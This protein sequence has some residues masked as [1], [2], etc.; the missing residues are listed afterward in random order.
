MFLL[1]AR[2]IALQKSSHQDIIEQ[3]QTYERARFDVAV[4]E[5]ALGKSVDAYGKAYRNDA[6]AWIDSDPAA[7]PR[8]R[9]IAAAFALEV[10]KIRFDADAKSWETLR[11]TIEW[12]CEQLRLNSMPLRGEHEWYLASVALAQRTLSRRWL[13]GLPD[14]NG[15]VWHLDHAQ[16]RFPDEARF[17]LVRAESQ[18]FD[19][20]RNLS[21]RARIAAITSPTGRGGPIAQA[22]SDNAISSFRELVNDLRV[23]PDA[24]IRVAHLLLS[25]DRYTSALEH[26]QRAATITDDA[27]TRYVAFVLEG[28][29]YEMLDRPADAG[30]AYA[31]ALAVMPR[32]QSA[33]LALSS[34]LLLSNQAQQAYDLAER[35][36]A[37]S[38][39]DD[40]WRLY[41]YGEFVRWPAYIAQLREAIK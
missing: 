40:P 9:L 38:V 12:S 13:T 39:S 3:L 23:A 15:A 14:S 28:K 2:V 7:R 36:L 16:A 37:A 6:R 22:Q 10:A 25:A 4:H 19:A 34:L 11:D 30:R 18:A 32:A 33:A 24:E 35:S 31:A 17:R 8:R 21:S 26:A 5:A 20:D 27:Q 1:A 29:A 41:Y